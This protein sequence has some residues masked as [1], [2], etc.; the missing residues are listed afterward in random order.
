MAKRI[1]MFEKIRDFFRFGFIIDSS[2]D[3]GIDS[4]G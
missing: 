4:T 1:K 2:I 3:S